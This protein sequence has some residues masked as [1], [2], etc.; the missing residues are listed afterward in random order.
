MPLPR[1]LQQSC[2]MPKIGVRLAET[3]KAYFYRLFCDLLRLYEAPWTGMKQVIGGERGIRTLEG[4]L[5]LTPLAGVRLRPLGHLSAGYKTLCFQRVMGVMR[6]PTRDAGGHD[7]Q[8]RHGRQ[9][10]QV[11]THSGGYARTPPPRRGQHRAPR[12]CPAR[13]R[14]IR[15]TAPASANQRRHGPD[16][17]AGLDA[18]GLIGRHAGDQHHLGRAL[19]TGEHDDGSLQALFQLIDRGTQRAGIGTVDPG[20][21]DLHAL[22][23]DRAGGQIDVPCPRP[24]CP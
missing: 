7:T 16:E 20:G 19:D 12:A 9:S 14:K 3:E 18:R 1:L 8:G 13:L 6:L 2:E 5:T 24:A 4:L 17:L 10:A 21:H 23:V 22:D 11:F 15:P